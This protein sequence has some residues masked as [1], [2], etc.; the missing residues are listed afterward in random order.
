MGLTF[1]QSGLM[2]LGSFLS[3][4]FMVE[5]LK[6][7]SI[8][9]GMGSTSLCCLLFGSI[10]F[11]L[12]VGGSVLNITNAVSVSKKTKSR[13]SLR[14]FYIFVFYPIIL[15]SFI[16]PAWESLFLTSLIFALPFLLIGAVVL[17]FSAITLHREASKLCKK[18]Y[19][20]TACGYCHFPFRRDVKALDGI[21]PRCGA[22]NEYP[23]VDKNRETETAGK[24]QGKRRK[25]GGK[26][27][28]ND[29]TEKKV[30]AG[31]AMT[32]WGGKGE[33]EETDK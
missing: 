15:I 29:P 24:K 4:I 28:Y 1:A 22:F 30:S 2:F 17:P 13:S 3:F 19:T 33:L 7:G 21:C 5:Y 25:K 23:I 27:G 16:I 32:E 12:L 18:E 6:W 14:S 20:T 8:S 10:G 31:M 26:G 9:A 11:I